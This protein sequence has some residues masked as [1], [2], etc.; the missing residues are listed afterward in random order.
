MNDAIVHHKVS[1]S[2]SETYCVS[3][4]VNKTRREGGV[5]DCVWSSELEFSVYITEQTLDGNHLLILC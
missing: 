4:S 1:A 5:I 3:D 2:V